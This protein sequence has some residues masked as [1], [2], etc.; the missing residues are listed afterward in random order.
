MENHKD[1]HRNHNVTIDVHFQNKLQSKHDHLDH[2]YN[3]FEMIMHDKDKRIDL[4]LHHNDQNEFL[5]ILT[6]HYNEENDIQMNKLNIFLKI[7]L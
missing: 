7:K 3:E 4:Q 6:E 2:E 5:I 1:F